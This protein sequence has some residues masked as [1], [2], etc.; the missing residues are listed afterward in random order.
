MLVA[1][2]VAVVAALVGRLRGGS[3]EGLAATSFRA[4]AVLWAGVAIQ[5]GIDVWDPEWLGEGAALAVL[6]GTNA[7]VAVFLALNH[8]FPGMIVAAAGMAL[9]VIVIAANGAMPVSRSGAAGV[10]L[11]DLGFKH[12]FLDESTRL[13]FLA[14]V[15]P[16][17]FLRTLISA[18]DVVLAAGI[19]WFVYGRMMSGDTM[20][21]AKRSTTSG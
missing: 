5:I 20:D 6:L 2:V 7:L 3:F 10:R 12:E 9:N 13:P 15:I 8:R 16:I 17:D 19:A 21:R 11:E 18:G 4:P 14:D 1:L